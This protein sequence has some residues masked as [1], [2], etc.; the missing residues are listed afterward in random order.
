MSS[1]EVKLIKKVNKPSDNS[2]EIVKEEQ[3]LLKDS[4]KKKDNNALTTKNKILIGI[5]ITAVALIAGYFG[6]GYLIY[7]DCVENHDSV[8]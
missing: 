4:E 1:D 5:G 2:L 8:F 3:Q 7:T 6:I